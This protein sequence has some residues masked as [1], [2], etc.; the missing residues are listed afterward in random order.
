MYFFTFL[1][2]AILLE[3][4]AASYVLETSYTSANWLDEFSFFTSAD[5]TAGYVNYVDQT[6]ATNN[7]Y[8]NT[9]NGHVYMG[10]D[11][12]NIASG[13]GRN[14]VRITSNAVYNYGLFALDVSHMPGGICGTWPAFWMF[15]PNWPNDGEIDIIEGVND[16]ANNAMTLHTSNGCSITDSSFTGTMTTSNCYVDAPNQ[17]TNSG[18]DI[19]DQTTQSYG[20]EFNSN[21]GGVIAMEWTSSDI[22]IWFFPRGTAPSDLEAKKPNPASWKEPVAQYQGDCNI[23]SHF[24]NMSIVLNTDFCG[25]WAGDVWGYSSYCSSLADSCND[26]VQNNPSAFANAS[27]LI[28]S[29]NVYQSNGNATA[30][31]SVAVSPAGHQ[32]NQTAP[33]LSTPLAMGG[34]L[35]N[36][37]KK[38]MMRKG[39]SMMGGNWLK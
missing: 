32:K 15:G 10:V 26:Y 31:S 27:W 34:G 11:S 36:P 20:T 22:N 29:L 37:P 13:S 24:A 5:P 18:C 16:N 35:P 1:F 9:D 12:T 33:L 2:Q 38:R 14:S 39:R 7:G 28:N 8:I 21:G 6:T 25:D 19:Q 17:S 30:A 3:I 4:C 23:P